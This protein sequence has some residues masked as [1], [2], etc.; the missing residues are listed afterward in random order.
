M[1]APALAGGG[2]AAAGGRLGLVVQATSHVSDVRIEL[3]GSNLRDLLKGLARRRR[4]SRMQKTVGRFVDVAR[5]GLERPGFRSPYLVMVTLTYRRADDWSPR[6][7]SAFVQRVSEWFERRRLPYAYAW[8]LELQ[9]RGAPHY[10][11]LFWV[12]HGT[13]LPKPDQCGPRQR[14][15]FWPHGSTN[16]TK[17]R[18][19]GYVVK[20]TSKGDCSP[21]PRGARIFGV[22]ASERCWR[23][24]A[25]WAAMPAWLR[26]RSFEGDRFVRLGSDWV[27]TVTGEVYGPSPWRFGFFRVGARWRV[28][29]EC[30]D[31]PDD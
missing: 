23:E 28:W 17:A 8:A 14:V 20:Y 25:R 29:L 2:A 6:H 26:R 18:S 3:E 24:F 22:G 10:H 4:I 16:I 7:V 27:S 1:R 30:R 9:Q 5:E 31:A 12:P 21:F 19:V 11:V 15:P 13:R